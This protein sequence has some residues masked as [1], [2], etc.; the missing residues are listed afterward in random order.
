ML[1][2]VLPLRSCRTCR[3][4]RL[5]T[6]ARHRCERSTRSDS[7]ALGFLET[8]SRLCGESL[9]VFEGLNRGQALERLK[10]DEAA[11]SP[12][13]GTYIDFVEASERG[14]SNGTRDLDLQSSW[15]S[16]H[17]MTTCAAV[18]CAVVD[19]RFALVGVL[20]RG[21]VHSSC[22]SIHHRSRKSEVSHQLR[23]R[24]EACEGGRSRGALGPRDAALSQPE[25]EMLRRYFGLP[26]PA[27]PRSRG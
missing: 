26:T 12:L 17:P 8:I 16:M 27:E 6:A 14:L 24:P 4:S 10:A 11:G 3:P 19:A 22:R 23:P 2:Q 21:E 9:S 20:C 1:W 25:D 15:G 5:R 7:S 13:A 18:F